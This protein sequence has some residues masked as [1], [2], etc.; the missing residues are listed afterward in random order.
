MTAPNSPANNN[1]KQRNYKDILSLK[2]N[3]EFYSFDQAI[4]RPRIRKTPRELERKRRDEHS[5]IA[6]PPQNTLLTS[7]ERFIVARNRNEDR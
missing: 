6:K 5:D 2:I 3:P 4:Q 7:M 1:F